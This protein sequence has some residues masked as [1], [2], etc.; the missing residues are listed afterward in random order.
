MKAISLWQPWATLVVLGQKQFE[1]RSWSTEYRG[2]LA[3]HAARTWNDDLRALIG[4]EPFASALGSIGGLPFGA[5]VCVV[6]LVDVIPITPDFSR[7]L[8]ATEREFGLYTSGRFAWR[9][10]DVRPVRVVS[11]PGRQ[12]LFNLPAQVAADIRQQLAGAEVRV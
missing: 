11:C 10:A 3:V 8:S 2:A 4:R 9:F 1:T 7:T 5:I 12:R 6:R